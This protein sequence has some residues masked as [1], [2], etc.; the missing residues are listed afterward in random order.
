MGK[1]IRYNKICN[2]K[3]SYGS[4]H[5]YISDKINGNSEISGVYIAKDVFENKKPP[6]HIKISIEWT[7]EDIDPEEISITVKTTLN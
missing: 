2:I 3:Q 6:E 5:Q 4:C 7:D 1:I